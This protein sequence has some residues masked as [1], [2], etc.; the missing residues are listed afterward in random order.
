MK[1]DSIKPQKHQGND[2][3][4]P[5]PVSRLSANMPLVDLAK[6]ISQ[7]DNMVSTRVNG[8]LKVIAEQIRHLQN[9]ARSILE[10]GNRD[11]E[12]HH[13]ECN[14]IRQP[15]KTYYL[16]KRQN[17]ST[18]FSMLSL[19]DWHQQPPHQFIAA[20][21]LE[22]DMSWTPVTDTRIIDDHISLV[23]KLLNQDNKGI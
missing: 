7:A 3:T 15:G 18:Y 20:Y 14:F 5:Y 12:L 4:S 21:T 23:E 13:A 16:Y 1:N 17:N 9:Q 2:S 6:E 10:K 8:Q 22:S 19:D 11:Q